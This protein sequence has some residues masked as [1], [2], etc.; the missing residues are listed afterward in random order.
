MCLGFRAYVTNL[1]FRGWPFAFTEA[2]KGPV[3]TLH[4][5]LQLP[6][7]C[8]A[9]MYVYCKY[10]AL[11]DYVCNA[12]YKSVHLHKNDAVRARAYQYIV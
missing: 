11:D 8:C 3:V 10:I 12:T 6:L 1:G 5:Y 7:I 9:Y 2:P 4:E